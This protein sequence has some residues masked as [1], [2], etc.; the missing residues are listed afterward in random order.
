MGRKG[1]QSPKTGAHIIKT[2][3]DDVTVT[4]QPPRQVFKLDVDSEYSGITTRKC[5]FPNAASNI[6]LRSTQYEMHQKTLALD[7]I[8]IDSNGKRSKQVCRT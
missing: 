4:K 3:L 7:R 5:T 8:D 1:K 6:D 2:S